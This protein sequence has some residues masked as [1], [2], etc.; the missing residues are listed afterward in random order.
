MIFPWG[1]IAQVLFAIALLA[2]IQSPKQCAGIFGPND[3][4]GATVQGWL[5]KIEKNT[6]R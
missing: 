2:A 3:V 1:H 6:R 5:E 4:Y